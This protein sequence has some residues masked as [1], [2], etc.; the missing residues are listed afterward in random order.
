MDRRNIVGYI[1][2]KKIKTIDWNT[3]GYIISI[4]LIYISFVLMSLYVP[5]ITDDYANVMRM[6]AVE[7]VRDYFI[8]LKDYI[9]DLY[10]HWSGRVIPAIWVCLI[11]WMSNETYAICNA[12]VYV[13]VFV[14]ITNIIT[15]EKNEK[16][17][18][19]I[20]LNTLFWVTMPNFG[21]A[22]F[23]RNGSGA[24]LWASI[25]PILAL[26]I[27]NNIHLFSTLSKVFQYFIM[28][29]IGFIGGLSHENMVVGMLVV[30]TLEMLYDKFFE[31]KH[32]DYR[33]IVMYISSILG[34]VVLIIAPGNYARLKVA[35]KTF[36]MTYTFIAICYYWMTIMWPICV[37]FFIEVLYLIKQKKYYV[38]KH[39]IY[40]LA[41]LVS[42]FCMI[43]ARQS[44]ERTWYIVVIYGLITILK[45]SLE[46]DPV[47]VKDNI[48]L[49]NI[50][51]VGCMIFLLVGYADTF[52]MNH[53]LYSQ[54]KTR[55]TI[56]EESKKSGIIDVEVPAMQYHYSLRHHHDAMVGGRDISTD[57]NYWVNVSVSKYYG[58]NSIRAKFE[59]SHL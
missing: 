42:A 2:K 1:A 8:N 49:K 50:V 22:I 9:N 18:I 54:F 21:E 43:F 20:L 4:F 23:W 25:T 13:S 16:V 51:I 41:A 47:K 26:V 46:L 3:R 14:M 56:I 27:W 35:E 17:F 55:E 28:I 58:I 57:P 10:F 30:M 32:I 45:L 31:K 7:S 36:S 53:D 29:V 39:S 6:S 5:L 15:V 11:S 19:F 38:M 24:Y 34:F 44:P 59:G 48:I 33:Y 12:L 37:V 52:V 40:L